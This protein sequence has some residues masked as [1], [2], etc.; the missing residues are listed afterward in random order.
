MAAEQVSA[1]QLVT[2]VNLATL[3]AQ[4][5]TFDG[6]DTKTSWILL[7]DAGV[8]AGA[9]TALAAAQ[10]RNWALWAAVLLGALLLITS[11]VA[12]ALVVLWPQPFRTFNLR[13]LHERH[14]SDTL[15][16]ARKTISSHA[17]TSYEVNERTIC[18]KGIGL[19]ISIAAMIAGIGLLV[20]G[21]CAAIGLSP[22]ASSGAAAPTGIDNHDH[23][24]R[25]SAD[26][27]ADR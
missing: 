7:I 8:L 9:V 12:G 2:E 17:V 22:A 19:R 25:H 18:R 15:D 6:L 16:N 24:Q 26:L 5:D 20:M 4:Q 13:A 10:V 14:F 11:L 21:T 3:Q 27:G 1:A 23:H